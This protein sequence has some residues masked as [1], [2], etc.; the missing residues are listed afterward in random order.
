MRSRFDYDEYK[1]W[2][3]NLGIATSEFRLWLKKFLLQEAQRV[4]AKAK[5]RQREVGAIDT[6][7]MI[8]SWGIGNQ[9]IK[10]KNTSDNYHVTIDP[11]RSTVADIRVINNVL[12]VEIWNAMEYA[13]FIEY[14]QRSYTGKYLLTVA[15]DEVERQLP[16][17]FN[18]AWLEFLREK[19]V[20]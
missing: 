1:Q 6:G 10:L 15:I 13:S 5:R 20:G 8:N 12:E 4:V 3:N 16:A 18:R 2:V 14:G 7:A 9:I 19:G 17:R 11:D